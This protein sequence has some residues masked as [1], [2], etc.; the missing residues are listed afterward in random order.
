MKIALVSDEYH[1]INNYVQKW[2]EN[3][4]YKLMLFG[5]YES[6]QDQPWIEVTIAAAKAVTNGI[7][8]EGIFFCWSGTGA[9]IIANKIAGI[10]A[11]LCN[12]QETANLARIWNDANVL[13]LS[14]RSLNENSADVILTNWFSKHE[15]KITEKELRQISKLEENL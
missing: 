4:G 5:S 15:K 8:D 1:P 2:L 14:N 10:R 11:A 12:D 7:C 9:S 13:V 6:K 3:K